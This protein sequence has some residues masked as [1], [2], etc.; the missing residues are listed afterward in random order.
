[1][2][3]FRFLVLEAARSRGLE[4]VVVAI[5]EETFKEIEACSS[6]VHWI[7]LGQLGKLIKIFQ[8]EGVTQAIM[9]GQVK[10]SQIFSTILPD[11]KMLKLL[12][13][14][15]V[16]KHGCSDRCG[17]PGFGGGR[18]HPDRLYDLSWTAFASAGGADAAVTQSR[19]K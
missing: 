16:E 12:D 17:C 7:S 11:L 6:T 9:A 13:E 5:L 1:M 15:E 3:S 4:M 10:H 18:H 2:E 8:Q 14:S 19:R